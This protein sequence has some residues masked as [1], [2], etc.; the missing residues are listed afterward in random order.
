MS[1][2]NQDFKLASS[3]YDDIFSD[4]IEDQITISRIFDNILKLK[5]AHV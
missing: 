4:D 3:C 2:I 5:A 1:Q